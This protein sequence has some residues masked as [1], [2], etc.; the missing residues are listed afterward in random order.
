[1]LEAKTMGNAA[2]DIPAEQERLDA[3]CDRFVN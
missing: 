3:S 2:K 1:M